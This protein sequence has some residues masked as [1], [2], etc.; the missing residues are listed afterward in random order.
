MTYNPKPI[1][2]D[3]KLR[4]AVPRK[5]VEGDG[6]LQKTAFIPASH[7]G[8]MSTLR[9]SVDPADITDKMLGTGPLAGIWP[10]E[11]AWLATDHLATLDDGGLPCACPDPA[12]VDRY[13]EGHASADYRGSTKSLRERIARRLRD[14]AAAAGPLMTFE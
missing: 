13:P 12:C 2:G 14:L 7:D 4:R 5:L 11:N 1:T 9:E 3:E 10:V 8:M 6:S